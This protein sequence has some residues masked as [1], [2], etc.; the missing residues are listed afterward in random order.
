MDGMS[1]KV[2]ILAP[3][4]SYD[5]MRAAMNAGADAV[6]I[7][8]SSF[9]ARAYA[10][11]PDEELLLKAIDEAHIRG[12]KIYLT[13]NTLLKENE[14]A[15]QLYN[16]LQN[17]YQ[18]GLDAVIV[19]DAGVL[20]FIHRHFPELPI[21]AST[22]MTLTMAQGAELLRNYGVTRLVASRELSLKEIKA[23]SDNTDMEIEAFVHGAL[24]Y[25][26]SGQCLMSSLI[27]GRSGNRGR[28]AQPC[29][30][31][32]RLYSG[33]KCLSGSQEIYLLSPKDINTLAIIPEMVEA[34]IDSFK[35]E[36]RMKSPEYAAITSYIYRK[37]LDLYFSLGAQGY[38][39]YIQG[40]DFA[41]DML[42]LQ[43]VYNRG[44]FSQGY[45]RTYHGKQMMS[46]S[47]PNHSGVF[48][49]KVKAVSEGS[50]DIIL[51]EELN[52]QDVLEIRRGQEKIYEFTI[53]D[54]HKAGELIKV[55]LP[56]SSDRHA[57]AKK[58]DYAV[59]NAKA[60]D[61]VLAEDELY[62]TRNNALL[63]YIAEKY[64]KKDA[65]YPVSGR[66]KARLGEKLSLNLSY[67]RYSITAYHDVVEQAKNQPVTRDRIKAQLEKTGDTL[68]YFEELLIDADDNIFIPVARLN[69]LRRNAILQL[70]EKI[71]KSFRRTLGKPACDG[72][73]EP[74]LFA[75]DSKE[76]DIKINA[77]KTK[78]IAADDDMKD[79]MSGSPGIA[80]SIQSLSQWKAA[81]A[82]DEVTA[83]YANYD[84]LQISD[85]L[86]M[87]ARTSK[88][89]KAFY[90]T[91]PHICRLPVYKRLER[92]LTE[93]AEND[94][95]NGY[96]VK[97]L[98]EKSLLNTLYKKR[99]AK[100]HIILN[101]NM[102][103]YNKEAKSFWNELGIGHFTAALELNY[104]ELKKLGVSDCDMVVYGYIPL[105]ISAQCVFDNTDACKKVKTAGAD[106]AEES[107][108]GILTDRLDK[109][110]FAKAFCRDCYNVIYNGQPL[111][112]HKQA[113]E[114]TALK[115]KNIRL[116]FCI[117]SDEQVK[118]ILNIFI[119]RYRYGNA[120]EDSIDDYTTGHYKRGVL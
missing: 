20:H 37:Y 10:E 21:H 31:P 120:V 72:K 79:K 41:K 32:Y 108:N 46:L 102:Y 69:E 82:F 53:K 48:V 118:K 45:S 42:K 96:V 77:N 111:A 113:D 60:L 12:K 93:I 78:E 109:K 116:D 57:P 117:E 18:R 63:D 28:C 84:T 89:G 95:I 23:I 94:T 44:G 112:L 50:A 49:G 9:G 101:Y 39:S 2:E 83:I 55:K 90:L 73:A 100:K 59:R 6:Y 30:K 35:I 36:G 74:V 43:D 26:Y 51:K 71:T 87:A 76:D 15:D 27:G 103:V 40:E 107:N 38:R 7:G 70:E 86:M 33:G 81:L 25:C 106:S 16:Y 115:V 104:K 62:R 11:N 61:N 99:E 80:V 5:S 8:G 47:R 65:R 4:G 97:N 14:L 56:R 19:Q 68:F 13:V 75:C 22:Q 1:K 92:D 85:I 110:F 54:M 66:L 29:R 67:G 98:E 64:I 114:I 17:Y 105:M 34:G 88:E 24:C 3:A 52:A 91:L 58:D 119:N